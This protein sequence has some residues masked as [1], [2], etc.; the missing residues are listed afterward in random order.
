MKVNDLV[1]RQYN[2]K[3]KKSLEDD[4][5][6]LRDDFLDRPYVLEFLKMHNAL[7][8]NFDYL[9]MQFDVDSWK[10]DL[11][12]WWEDCSE[13]EITCSIDPQELD[14]FMFDDNYMIDLLKEKERIDRYELYKKLK[15]EFESHD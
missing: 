7:I 14:K 9:E 1:K 6:K 11:Y 12:V 4:W 8:L 5:N 15:E 3:E 10:I 2:D 13:K